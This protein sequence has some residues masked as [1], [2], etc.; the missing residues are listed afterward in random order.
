MYARSSELVWV[1]EEVSCCFFLY[2]FGGSAAIHR[3]VRSSRTEASVFVEI[4]GKAA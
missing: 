3:A 2:V 1:D 4:R